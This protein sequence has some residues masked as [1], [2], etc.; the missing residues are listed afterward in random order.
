MDNLK[1]YLVWILMAAFLGTVAACAPTSERRGTGEVID[2]A[3]L[4]ARVKT[5]LVKVEGISAFKVDVNTNRGEVQLTGFVR[6]DDM[7]RRS[8]E[9]AR[10]VPGVVRVH[11]DLRVAPRR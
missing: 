7:V 10:T 11:N 6:D 1:K 5:A 9:T 3:T 2:D 8:V 4:T